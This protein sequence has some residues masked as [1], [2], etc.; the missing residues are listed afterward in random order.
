[1]EDASHDGLAKT[2]AAQTWPTPEFCSDADLVAEMKA[3]LAQ[4]TWSSNRGIWVDA[5]DG[6]IALVGVVNSEDEKAALATIARGIDGCRGVENHL[7][8]K[9]KWRDYGIAY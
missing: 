9:S 3:R 8:V 7:L 5:R 6:T 1:M 2:P 4:E